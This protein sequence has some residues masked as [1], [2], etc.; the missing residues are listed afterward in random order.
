MSGGLAGVA[1]YAG[2]S[3]AQAIYVSILANTQSS[4]AANAVPK[5]AMQ[6]GA[7]EGT[8]AA[9]LA[10]F[11]L[12]STALAKVPGVNDKILA[13]AGTAYQWSYAH[14]LKI[15]ALSSLSFGLVGLILCLLTEN[16]DKKVSGFTAKSL[17]PANERQMNSQTNVFLE[18]DV[19]A[20]KNEFH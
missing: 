15:T 20:E 6:A 17:V 2:G 19:N 18:N 13:A 11:P 10:A 9:V 8:A 12:G 4:Y 7:S 1:R 3:L 16:I 14:G 5:A